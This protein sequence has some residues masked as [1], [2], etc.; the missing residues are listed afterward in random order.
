MKKRMLKKLDVERV[1]EYEPGELQ[2]KAL[3][4][5][6]D[7]YESIHHQ[8]LEELPIFLALVAEFIQIMIFRAVHV[9]AQLYYEVYRTLNPLIS[10]LKISEYSTTQDI[11]KDFISAMSQGNIEAAATGEILGGW[12]KKVWG[13]IKL[14]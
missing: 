6:A 3:L 13:M 14:M 11:P 5:S 8:L 12:K 1:A 9:Q 4:E 2:D 10:L 7:A